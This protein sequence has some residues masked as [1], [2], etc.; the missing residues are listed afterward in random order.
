M[1]SADERLQAIAAKSH[2]EALYHVKW[3]SDWVIRLGDGTPESHERMQKAIDALWPYKGEL[4]SPNEVEQE[5]L[6]LGYGVDL[7]VLKNRRDQKI[8]EVLTEATLSI[9]QDQYV[10]E[11]GKDGRHSE[12]LGYILADL[13]FLQR[14]YPGLEW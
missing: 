8:E 6:R 11:G 3:S 5:A 14:S 1:H 4:T 13:Q 10:Q 7:D 12:H 9:P 2:K